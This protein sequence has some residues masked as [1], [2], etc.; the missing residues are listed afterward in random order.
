MIKD[1]HQNSITLEKLV[2][3]YVE[4]G[5]M[6][7]VIVD[8][9]EK[10]L[11][12]PMLQSEIMGSI[13]NEIQASITQEEADAIHRN[14]KAK[15]H[16]RETRERIQ[17]IRNLLLEGIVFTFFVGLLVNLATEL[18]NTFFPDHKAIIAIICIVIIAILYYSRLLGQIQA[19]LYPD[20]EGD[21]DPL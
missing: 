5:M 11:I 3:F 21:S 19:L 13:R 4:R 20:Q 17:Q 2:T 16:R 9:R 14:A 10:Q 7:S 15:C 1:S 6:D 8:S 18:L 12:A